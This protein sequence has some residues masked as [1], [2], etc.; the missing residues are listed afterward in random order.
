MLVDMV[1]KI[2]KV[3]SEII[4]FCMFL[5]SFCFLKLIVSKFD[6]MRGN[7]YKNGVIKWRFVIFYFL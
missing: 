7:I 3:M 2:L 4:Y 1:K 5:V 6:V